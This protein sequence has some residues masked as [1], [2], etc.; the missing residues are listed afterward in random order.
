MVIDKGSLIMWPGAGKVPRYG[1]GRGKPN[2][3]P[4]WARL[5]GVS[6]ESQAYLRAFA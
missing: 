6:A 1:T 2:Q 5:S 3:A 4:R